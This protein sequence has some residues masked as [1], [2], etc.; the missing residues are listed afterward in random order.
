MEKVRQNPQVPQTKNYELEKLNGKDNLYGVVLHYTRKGTQH[1]LDCTINKLQ[2]EFP[3][4][5]LRLAEYGLY[6]KIQR[7]TAGKQTDAEK[8]D[9]MIETIEL[10]RSG[11]WEKPARS[12]KPKI[13]ADIVQKVQ[14]LLAQGLSPDEIAK[15]LQAGA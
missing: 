11:H 8:L 3:E 4:L 5:V 14:Q 7:S 1:T 13:T 6:V 12:K 2:A 15:I 10:L 9:A